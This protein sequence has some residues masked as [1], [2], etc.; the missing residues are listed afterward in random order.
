MTGQQGANQILGV[1]LTLIRINAV[2]PS[3]SV[4]SGGAAWAGVAWGSVASVNLS[5]ADRNS[6]WT[7]I[8]Q[9]MAVYFAS[10]KHTVRTTGTTCSRIEVVL[11]GDGAVYVLLHGTYTSQ[12]YEVPYPT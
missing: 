7:R 10:R 5:K 8:P 9:T 3:G 12:S 1:R 6:A 11:L 4:S 2:M